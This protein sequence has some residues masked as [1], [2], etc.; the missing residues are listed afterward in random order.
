MFLVSMFFFKIM[1][2]FLISFICDF[3]RLSYLKVFFS[4]ICQVK[5]ICDNMR[6]FQKK[7]TF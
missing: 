2:G 3:G 5:P 1:I 7:H 6:E 4:G